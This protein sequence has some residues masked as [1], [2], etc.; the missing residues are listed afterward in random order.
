[1][2]ALGGPLCAKS[3]HRGSGSTVGGKANPTALIACSLI[4][5]AQNGRTIPPG[6]RYSTRFAA[7]PYAKF[8]NPG[9]ERKI[10]EGLL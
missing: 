2:S 4:A 8:D 6:P 10:P 3:G 1:M 9:T 7:K 5:S